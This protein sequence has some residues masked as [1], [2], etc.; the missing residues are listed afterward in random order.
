MQG[1]PLVLECLPVFLHCWAPHHLLLL[2]SLH[3]ARWSPDAERRM[4][5]NGQADGEG[6]KGRAPRDRKG[7]DGW[8]QRGIKEERDR[9]REGGSQGNNGGRVI[10]KRRRYLYIHAH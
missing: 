8:R 10:R 5:R 1:L 7:A 3:G 2:P 6:D 9:G 4:R